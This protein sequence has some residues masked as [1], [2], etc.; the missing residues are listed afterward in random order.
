MRAEKLFFPEIVHQRRDAIADR[1]DPVAHARARDFD[2]FTAKGLL[3]AIERLMVAVFVD[4]HFRQ[5][6][7]TRQPLFHHLRRLGRRRDLLVAAFLAAVDEGH[8]LDHLERG[9][10]VVELLVDLFANR[11][12]RLVA[13]WAQTLGLGQWMLDAAT[14]NLLA[15][16]FALRAAARLRGLGFDRWLRFGFRRRLDTEPGHIDQG[17]LV[18]IELLGLWTEQFSRQLVELRLQ[19]FFAAVALAQLLIELANQRLEQGRIVRQRSGFGRDLHH[20]FGR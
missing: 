18:R 5:Q 1:L 9:G 11:R 2:A 12:H 14:G 7:G 17:Q 10:D 8:V 16:A 6:A 13:A 3:L 20:D 19:R 15:G 4:R